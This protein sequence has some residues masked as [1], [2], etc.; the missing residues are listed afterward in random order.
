MHATVQVYLHAQTTP[1]GANSVIVTA[2]PPSWDLHVVW[3]TE[4]RVESHCVRDTLNWKYGR[5]SLEVAVRGF[6]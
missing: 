2:P 5:E 3:K 6:N 4:F 1:V